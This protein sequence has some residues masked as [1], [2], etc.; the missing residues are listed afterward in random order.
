MPRRPRFRA[1]PHFVQQVVRIPAFSFRSDVA[2]SPA[3]WIGVLVLVAVGDYLTGQFIHSAVLFY[4]IP[5]GLAAWSSRSR[6]PS[7]VVACTWPVLRL[8]IIALW[9][10]PWPRGVTIQDAVVDALV[11]IGFATLV[12]NLRLQAR[13]IRTL[14]GILPMCSFCRRIRTDDGWE[15]V[16]TYLL[17][18]SDARISHTF[19]PDCGRSHYGDLGSPSDAGPAAG[20]TFTAPGRSS[21]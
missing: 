9:G 20:A 3:I 14:E 8:G 11:S 4:L 2:I 15:R 17:G 16:E 7:I 13:T 12:W 21:S 1:Q 19:C 5:V 10:W 18:H 6:W